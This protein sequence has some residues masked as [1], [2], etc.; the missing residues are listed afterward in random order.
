[1]ISNAGF[2]I[3]LQDQENK[4]AA[5]PARKSVLKNV[6]KPLGDRGVNQTPH[7]KLNLLKDSNINVKSVPKKEVIIKPQVKNTH[8]EWFSDMC[9]FKNVEDDYEDICLKSDRLDV[10][11]LLSFMLNP[12]TPPPCYTKEFFAPKIQTPQKKCYNYFDDDKLSEVPIIDVK[13]PW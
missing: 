5:L 10:K 4:E 6:R 12:K 9:S 2:R 1:M 3:S 13:L 8:P 7:P 11:D